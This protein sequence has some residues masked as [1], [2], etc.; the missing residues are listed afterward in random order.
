MAENLE[1]LRRRSALLWGSEARPARGPKRTLSADDVVQAAIAVADRD[2]LSALTM[3]AVAKE[4]GFTTMALYR[5]FPSKEALIDAIVDA[6]MG[7]PP[8]R[9]GPAGPWRDEVSRWA[10]AKRAMLMSRP[11]LA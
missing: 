7:T 1:E 9:T 6:A 5:Y 8:E 3:Q 2:G 10:H 11:W 4:V